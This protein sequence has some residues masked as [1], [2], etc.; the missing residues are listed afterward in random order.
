MR[1][2]LALVVL[3]ALPLPAVA[4][5]DDTANAQAPGQNLA[6]QSPVLVQPFG[7]D[8]TVA[9]PGQRPTLVQPFGNGYTVGQPGQPPTLVQPFGGGWIVYPPAFQM[10]PPGWQGN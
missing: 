7:N 10:V 1:I 3:V 8:Y 9:Q 6:P 4:Q 2:L 5:W